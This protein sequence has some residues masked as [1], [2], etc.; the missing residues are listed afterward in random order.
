MAASVTE[1]FENFL[2]VFHYLTISSVCHGLEELEMVSTK[3][4][5]SLLRYTNV[6]PADKAFYQAGVQAKAIGWDSMAFVLLNRFLDI[7]DI[8][9]DNNGGLTTTL[10]NSDFELTDIPFEKLLIPNQSSVSDAHREQIK[11]WVLAVSLD[12]RVQQQLPTDERGVYEATL[13]HGNRSDDALPCVVTGYPVLKNPVKFPA[14]DKMANREDWNRFL[15]ATKRYSENEQLH[16]I[17]KFIEKWCQG[18]PSAS[19]QFTF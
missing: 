7:A 4:V 5:V 9:E 19:S 8:V 3:A 14:K 12:Q 10:D 18:L 16:E 13:S 11:E 15:V 6:Y 2:L 1:E 17:L